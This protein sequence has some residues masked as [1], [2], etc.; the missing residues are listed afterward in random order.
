MEFKPSSSASLRKARLFQEIDNA[1]GDP[2]PEDIW[3]S[4]KWGRE[5]YL[6]SV[7]FDFKT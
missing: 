4:Q 5:E 3:G 7:L 2:M 1:E 6:G